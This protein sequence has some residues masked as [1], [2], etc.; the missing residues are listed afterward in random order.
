M[1]SMAD[2]YYDIE[3]KELLEQLDGLMKD[4]VVPGDKPA[5]A[6]GAKKVQD[7]KTALPQIK[8]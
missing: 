8:Q 3:T 4:A 6:T 7:Q 1:K 2:I 5:P